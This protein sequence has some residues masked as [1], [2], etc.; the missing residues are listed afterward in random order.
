MRH[1]SSHALLLTSRLQLQRGDLCLQVAAVSAR[2]LALRT[3]L[4][5]RD[6]LD[7]VWMLEREPRHVQQCMLTWHC[8]KPLSVLMCILCSL[9]KAQELGCFVKLSLRL[10][11]RLLLADLASMYQQLMSVRVD[12]L[13]A[14]HT[15]VTSSSE[16]L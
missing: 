9:S 13:A 16:Q 10:L 1:A 11:C 4:G 3:M 7:L 14:S 12:N 2:V 5:S 8:M 15:Q 6:N